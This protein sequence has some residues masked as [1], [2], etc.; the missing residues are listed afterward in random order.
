MFPNRLTGKWEKKED[1][2]RFWPERREGSFC[3]QS[4][5]GCR[6]TRPGDGGTPRLAAK[7]GLDAGCMLEVTGAGTVSM[8]DVCSRAMG[9]G[10]CPWRTLARGDDHM[11]HVHIRKLGEATGTKA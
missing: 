8:E 3:Q 5:E 4:W 9:T 11:D 10:Q 6:G 1:R 2:S 7:N